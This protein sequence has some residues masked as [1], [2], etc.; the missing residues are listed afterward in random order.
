MVEIKYTVVMQYF[1]GGK[2]ANKPNW[3]SSARTQESEVQ[4]F[5]ISTM[6]N[7][8]GHISRIAMV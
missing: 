4:S 8:I 5:S 6:F 7:I 1:D 2:Q 3:G